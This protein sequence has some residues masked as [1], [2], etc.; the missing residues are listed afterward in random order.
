MQSDFQQD[1]SGITQDFDQPG[2][3]DGAEGYLPNDR[4][5]RLKLYGAYAITEEFILG[6][7]VTVESP[8]SLSCF[9]FHPGSDVTD[10][11]FENVYGQASHYCGGVLSPRGTAQKSEW[12]YQLDLSARYNVS[13]PNGQLVTFRAD[14]FNLLNMSAIQDRYEIGDIDD[15]FNPHPNFGL[16]RLYQAPRSIRLGMDVAF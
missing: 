9:G 16:A 13:I 14:V 8:R 1:D 15:A 5:H 6:S 4:R 7:N 3:I 11:S 12:V 10:G 2:F